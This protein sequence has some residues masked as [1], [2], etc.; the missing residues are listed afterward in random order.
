[1]NALVDHVEMLKAQNLDLEGRKKREAQ[2]YQADVAMLQQ[3]MKHVEQQM[4]KSAI[5]KSKGKARLCFKKCP[6]T[7]I[8]KNFLVS[9]LL[10][11][12]VYAIH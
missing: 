4:V 7:K 9:T 1:M 11:V 8:K 10:H 12:S 2:G 3:K 5:T 6:R